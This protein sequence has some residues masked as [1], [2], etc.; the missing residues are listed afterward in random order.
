MVPACAI[1]STAAKISARPPG[2]D[3]PRTSDPQDPARRAYLSGASSGCSNLLDLW[4]AASQD[5]PRLVRHPQHRRRRARATLDMTARSANRSPMLVAD[6]QA[7][8]GLAPPWLIGKTAKEYRAT[9]GRKPI[10][11]LFSVGLEELPLEGQRDQRRRDPH[12]GAGRD[13]QRHGPWFSK[14]CGTLHDERW[15]EASR[16]STSGTG[17]D[18]RY[19]RTSR[20]WRASPWSIR[21]RPPGSTAATEAEAKVEDYALGWYQ[22]LVESRIPFEMVHDQLL[23]AAHLAPVQDSHPAQHRRAQRRAVRPAARLRRRWRQHHRHPR[24]QPVRREGHAAKELRAGRSFRRGLDRQSEG[25]ML[26]S[27]IRLEHE[28]LPHIRS[29]PGLK[30]RRASSTASTGSR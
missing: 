3:L 29:L 4:N 15:L 28:A 6:R 11:G 13:R 18:E 12:L 17:A 24:N 27:Y 30:T 21:S 8:R 26:N 19:L 9:M 22:A 25:P 1:A 10:V 7:R 20:R 14:F 2:F 5:Q 16:R 23:D